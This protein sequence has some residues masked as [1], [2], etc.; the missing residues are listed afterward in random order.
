MT[1]LQALYYVFL[2]S[3]AAL[4]AVN[5]PCSADGTPG[6]C[7]S[8]ATCSDSAGTSHSG[9]CPDDPADIKCCTKPDCGSGGNC[10]WTSQCSGSSQAGLCPGPADFKCCLDGSDGGSPGGDGEATSTSHGLSANGVK[11][12]EN[13][14]G[15]SANFYQDSAV[16]GFFWFLAPRNPTEYFFLLLTRDSRASKPSVTATRVNQPLPAI[17]SKRPSR[18][19]QETISSTRTPP[20]LSLV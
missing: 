10:R 14:E 16:S 6:V 19:K 20:D 1:P 15:W 5:G 7:I 17:A 2:L 9:F 3:G 11:F 18:E 4:G 13:F 12:I 8:S